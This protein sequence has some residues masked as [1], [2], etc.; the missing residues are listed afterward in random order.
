MIIVIKLKYFIWNI[1]ILHFW[2]YFHRSKRVK[3]AH[4]TETLLSRDFY[5]F[6]KVWIQI[7]LNESSLKT[8]NLSLPSNCEFHSSSA[9]LS[10]FM[11]SSLE[12]ASSV[13]RSGIF[14]VVHIL[15]PRYLGLTAKLRL[16]LSVIYIFY[17]LKT[18][19]EYDRDWKFSKFI[20]SEVWSGFLKIWKF[21]RNRNSLKSGPSPHFGPVQNWGDLRKNILFNPDRSFKTRT[22]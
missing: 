19:P 3:K 9:N 7:N 20:Q 1:I 15:G 13:V 8:Y 16:V 11:L 17:L 2:K 5:L 14:Y 18:V 6:Q 4:W 12:K 22:V 10:R 21:S